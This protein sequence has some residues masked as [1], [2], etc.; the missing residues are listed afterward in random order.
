MSKCKDILKLE[1]DLA[2][3][4]ELIQ[5]VNNGIDNVAVG[6]VVLKEKLKPGYYRP[7]TAM[8]GVHFKQIGLQTDELL[9]FKNSKMEDITNEVDKFWSL[10]KDFKDMGFMHNR[11]VLLYGPPGTGK[12]CL[13]KQLVENMVKNGEVVFTTG[14]NLSSLVFG[15]KAFREVEPDRKLLV[16]ME[17]IDAIIRY[18]EH[19]LLEL[20]DG[21]IQI[22]NVLYL[23]TTNYINRIPERVKRPGRFDH[24]VEINYPDENGRRAYLENKLSKYENEQEIQK[25]VKQTKG[26]S[27]GHLREFLISV[28][29]LK[30][31]KAKILQRLGSK[32]YDQLTKSDQYTNDVISQAIRESYQ[33]YK[34]KKIF[35]LLS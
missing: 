30:K 32:T 27:F 26:F 24:L 31:D 9:T 23:G 2:K 16:V 22:D 25:L 12:S 28:Y 35:K 20:L 14:N 21:D 1:E 11:G 17:D 34:V 19:S 29:C 10:K 15:L 18:D 7:Y 4:R 3:P 8:D 13:I 5:Y 33:G 6:K